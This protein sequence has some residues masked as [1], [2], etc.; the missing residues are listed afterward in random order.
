[1]SNLNHDKSLDEKT[2]ELLNILTSQTDIYSVQQGDFYKV[3]IFELCDEHKIPSC[4]G[5]NSDNPY[6]SCAMELAPDQT[7]P[8]FI[9]VEEGKCLSFRLGLNEAVVITGKTPPEVKYF[10]YCVFL[11]SRHSKDENEEPFEVT[12]IRNIPIKLVRKVIQRDVVFDCLG[13]PINNLKINTP[14]TPG[15]TPGCPFSQ[16]FLIVFTANQDLLQQIYK[17]AIEAGFSPDSLN[18]AVIPKDIVNLGVASHDTDSFSL[19]NR[20]SSQDKKD[21][22][23]IKYLENP[24]VKVFR[25]TSNTITGP[26]LPIP[27][28]T[29]RGTGRTEF[30]YTKAVEKLRDKIT[31]FYSEDYDAVDIP[32]DIWLNE[33]Y[34][35]IQQGVNNLGEARDSIYFGTGT[36]KLPENA[37]IAVYGADHAKTGKCTYSNVVVY[38]SEYDNGVVNVNNKDLENSAF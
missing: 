8:N 35:A 30:Q 31:E 1:M 22:N 29:P 34:T 20:I 9:E 7:V 15:G 28:L 21:P 33:S 19:L 17:S 11:T 13:E 23:L 6:F 32:T 26:A 24:G 2:D 27:F 16:P 25:V 36:F 12:P 37:F 4:F 10:S 3:D 5:N 14:G 38:G 18:V